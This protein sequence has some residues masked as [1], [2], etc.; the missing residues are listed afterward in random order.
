MAMTETPSP[1]DLAT[2]LNARRGGFNELIGLTFTSATLEKVEAT[3]ELGP[4]HTQPYGIVHGGLYATIIETLCSTGAAIH[5]FSSGKG[6][7]GLENQTSFLRASRGGTLRANA[8]PLKTGRSSHVW[9]AEV[10]DDQGRVLAT[11]Q[12]RLMVLD[13]GSKVAGEAVKPGGA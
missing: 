6:V 5:V 11:G 13:E 7:V 10:R 1:T 8:T 2:M 4:Q 3:L 9:R 12:V